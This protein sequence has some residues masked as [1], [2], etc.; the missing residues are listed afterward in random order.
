MWACGGCCIEAVFHIF[1]GGFSGVVL[2]GHGAIV[3]LISQEVAHCFSTVCTLIFFLPQ[4]AQLP[5]SHILTNTCSFLPY[6]FLKVA[7]TTGVIPMKFW[8]AFP[9]WLTLT[10]F[11]TYILAIY[12]C[13]FENCLFGYII[14]FY[15]VIIFFCY[16]CFRLFYMYKSWLCQIL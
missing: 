3:F 16:W 15:Q 9:W 5:T 11:D 1:S 14:H 12:I 7:S 13:S 8:F 6:F 4:W 10:P 2:L